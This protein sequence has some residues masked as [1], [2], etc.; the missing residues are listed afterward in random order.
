[1][2]KTFLKKCLNIL[3]IQV[4]LITQF[5]STVRV[6]WLTATAIA[7]ATTISTFSFADAFDDAAAE[8]QN[9]AAGL[10]KE[11]G[12]DTRNGTM[13]YT[14]P[15]GSKTTQGLGQFFPSS[16][17]VDDTS[18]LSGAVGDGPA[19]GN[20][21]DSINTR[22]E[23]ENSAQGEAYRTI[24]DVVGSSSHANRKTDP[25]FDT[26]KAILDTDDPAFDM[27]LRGCT[28]VTTTSAPHVP[29]Y[30][31]CNNYTQKATSC[32]VG[33]EIEKAVF[34]ILGANSAI[35]SCGAG[36]LDIVV[37]STTNNVTA[38]GGACQ[39]KSTSATI[40]VSNPEAITGAVLTGVKYSGR[41][42]LAVDNQNLWVGTTGGIADIGAVPVNDP[43]CQST[44]TQDDALN[45][46]VTADIKKTGTITVQLEHTLN[47]SAYAEATIRVN[48]NPAALTSDTWTPQSCIDIGNSSS[49]S[50]CSINTV[51][52]AGPDQ[53]GCITTENGKQICTGDP[54]YTSLQPS[55]L[56]SVSKLCQLA[57]VTEDCSF[58]SGM[59]SSW[60]DATGAGRTIG[61]GLPTI[62]TCGAYDTNSSCAF[63]ESSCI[64]GATDT[65]GKC[66]GTDVT[67]DCGYVASGGATVTCTSDSSGA[68]I[69]DTAFTGCTTTTDTQE[70]TVI[71]RI[72]DLKTCETLQ[73]PANRSCTATRELDVRAAQGIVQVGVIGYNINT[74]RIDL[75]NG[76]YTMIAQSDAIAMRAGNNY[77]NIPTI[78]MNEVC[79]A[80]ATI[81]LSSIKPWVP[82]LPNDLDGGNTPV[83]VQAPSCQNNLI[84][85]VKLTDTNGLGD[86]DLYGGEFTFN[87][88]RVVKDEWTYENPECE[89]TGIQILDGFCGDG[90]VSCT[91]HNQSCIVE[92][93]VSV[94]AP[95]IKSSLYGGV[96][97]ACLSLEITNNGCQFNNGALACWTDPQGVE[98][99]PTNDSTFTD[100]CSV[101][102]SDP[103][104]VYI[105]EQCI[106]GVAGASGACYAFTRL[107][108]CGKDVPITNIVSTTST[109]C[110]GAIRCMGGDCVTRTSESNPDFG[111]AAATLAAA[112]FMAMETS[113][114]EQ[115][116]AASCEMFKGDALECKKALG[117]Y[118]DCCETPSGVSLQDYLTLAK[119]T[120]EVSEQ[121]GAIDALSQSYQNVAGT[122]TKQLVGDV[123]SSAKD[124]ADPINS[125]Y[126]N[127]VTYVTGESL[128]EIA[129]QA[130][131]G[132]FASNV[133]E[134]FGPATIKE[135]ASQIAGEFLSSTFSP[136]VA[137]SLLESST[138][139]LTKNGVETVTTEFTGGLASNGA[140][141]VLGAIMFA[142]MIYSIINI[143]IQIIWACEEEE[144]ELG[145]KRELKSCHFVGSYCADKVL[146]S[147]IEK[148]DSYCCYSSPFARIVQEQGRPQIG[149]GFGSAKK[150][151]CGGLSVAV[152]EQLDWDQIDLSEWVAILNDTGLVASPTDALTKFQLE[153][154][155][156]GGIGQN[157]GQEIQGLIDITDQ[158]ATH[159]S[160]RENLWGN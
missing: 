89:A 112:D 34:N 84:G 43:S 121:L 39:R 66:Y 5:A 100:T 129:F 114:V 131:T 127:L 10:L 87:Y 48:Y 35:T 6:T 158:E 74:F 47:D 9:S 16:G 86:I 98:H 99:C 30:Q 18:T 115:G 147:C 21:T 4:F 141:A 91:L 20:A 3:F 12:M 85:I 71:N 73:Q 101:L 50:F 40:Q 139:T 8:G 44:T 82:P 124:I 65:G 62:S 140:G 104:C 146:G 119:S 126:E 154:T 64:P 156:G 77:G 159:D 90:A 132:D 116:N 153:S 36:C 75:K 2:K 94:C 26:A 105:E 55:P 25:V 79:G 122:W 123:T 83:L 137:T 59:A 69:F 113:C 80:G 103:S 96:G 42:T 143:L 60:T 57:K 11:F 155:T 118:V 111:K 1:M 53:Y 41:V 31:K 92:N 106:D 54:E 95:D 151:E 102:N 109:T 49:T 110:D 76:T 97:D 81:E 117:G 142:Y 93:G 52:L 38:S 28:P 68:P 33:H 108:D 107:Y 45:L 160:V 29:N 70:S 7:S 46:D 144:F 135:Q 157:A 133:I 13:T 63:V 27:V 149:Q 136:E 134:T 125:A 72:P 130:G 61:D 17:G 15:D 14:N 152:I 58:V 138:S 145:V 128:P 37:G 51:C 24:R 32:Q 150:P 120:Y 148:R 19:I 67:Y 23:T 56:S 88:K 78:D 22:L